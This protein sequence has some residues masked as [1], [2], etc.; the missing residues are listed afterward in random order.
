MLKEAATPKEMYK[1][2]SSTCQFEGA[3]TELEE[4][5]RNFR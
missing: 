5:T 3:R 4:S 2:F 1:L